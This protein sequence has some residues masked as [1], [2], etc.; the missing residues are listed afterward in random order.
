MK[1]NCYDFSRRFNG[2]HKKDWPPFSYQ[3]RLED[4]KHV[5][6]KKQQLSLK[7]LKKETIRNHIRSFMRTLE[8]RQEFVPPLGKYVNAGKAEPLHLKNNVCKE[9]F[10]KILQVV[11]L[12]ADIES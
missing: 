5:V 12:M 9:M 7:C 2:K 3:K 8:S 10:S 11:M 6:K 1:E 4:V